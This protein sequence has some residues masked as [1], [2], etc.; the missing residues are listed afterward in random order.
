MSTKVNTRSHSIVVVDEVAHLLD[1]VVVK[2]E[3]MDSA[4]I[5]SLVQQ[6]ETPDTTAQR[7]VMDELELEGSEAIGVLA[8]NLA[9]SSPRVKAALVQ[10]MGAIGDESALL[11]LMRYVWDSRQ[12]IQESTARGLAMKAIV[13]IAGPQHASRMLSFLLDTSRDQDPFVRGWVAQALGNFGDPSARPILTDML[14]DDDLTVR[15]HAEQALQRL[16]DADGSALDQSL[17]ATTLLTRIRQSQGGQQEFYMEQLKQRED[18][19]ELAATLVREGGRGTIRGLHFLGE[20]NDGRARLIAGR[21]LER[22]PQ[23]PHRAIA[24]SVIARHLAQDA[25]E[26]EKALIRASFYDT[27]HF[28][29]VT[30]VECAA[31]SGD[32]ELIQRAVDALFKPELEAIHAAARGLSKGLGPRNRAL[33]P[34]LLEAFDRIH[35]R[36]LKE[37]SD[38]LIRGEAYLV[39]AINR[40]IE[41]GA[42]GLSQA[43]NVALRSL[44]DADHHRPLLI[45]GL[46]LLETTTPNVLPA[47]Q[48]WDATQTRALAALLDSSD[49]QIRDRA[50]EL[51]HRGGAKGMDIL[52]PAIERIL[53]D[54]DADLET[55]ILVLEHVNSSRAK[56]VLTEVATSDSLASISAHAALKRMR[57]NADWIDAEFDEGTF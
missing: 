31:L 8:A 56:Q 24:M 15:E 5:A 17:D 49:R 25:D 26:A 45:T 54:P 11:P 33:F 14:R 57:D 46:E 36:R 12:A 20:V 7:A 43:R 39:R 41:P 21:F 23:S 37:Y 27:D 9:F 48:R 30:G 55:A 4:Y 40:L 2:E 32:E 51:I 44:F 10:V 42:L 28:M 34:K 16:R 1:R 50:L 22:E 3:P 6:L 47:D 13:E 53:F 18:A 19:L 29:R 35:K 38:L 52:V